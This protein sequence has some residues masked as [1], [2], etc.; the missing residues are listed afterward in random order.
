MG[1]IDIFRD[2]V[3]CSQFLLSEDVRTRT[4]DPIFFQQDVVDERLE[5]R[6]LSYVGSFVP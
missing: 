2:A 5:D 4:T 1:G 6:P 3:I